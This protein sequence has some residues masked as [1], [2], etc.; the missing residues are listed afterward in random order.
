MRSCQGALLLIDATQG[1]QAQ[2]IANY[3]LAKKENLKV[4]PVFNKIDAICDIDTMEREARQEL[5]LEGPISKV[6]AKTGQNVESLLSRI[7]EEVPPPTVGKVND[8]LKLFLVNSW[9]VSNKNVICLFYVMDGELKKGKTIV[10][11]YTG[12]SYQVFEVGMLQPELNACESLNPGQIGYAISNM[13]QVKQAHIGD[14]F[15]L[16]GKKV[17][18]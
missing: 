1:I 14:T 12:K 16:L 6:S 10:S 7:I 15:H 5:K 13:K 4:I 2:T 3:E 18:P 8:P 9:F 11:S 17:P